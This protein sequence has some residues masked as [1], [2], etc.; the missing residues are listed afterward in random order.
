M[1]GIALRLTWSDDPVKV[2]HSRCFSKG[3][4]PLRQFNTVMLRMCMDRM[5]AEPLPP[6]EDAVKVQSAFRIKPIGP[7][8]AMSLHTSAMPQESRSPF[9]N[10]VVSFQR[11]F[12]PDEICPQ[13]SH[14][15]F[16][17]T[18]CYFFNGLIRSGWVFSTGHVHLH[19][20]SPRRGE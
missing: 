14:A 16:P 10:Y 8:P 5:M 3:A 18:N 20:P 2:R 6:R 17:P 7:V 4:G 19:S 9:R 15:S 1:R 12:T 13:R 11:L